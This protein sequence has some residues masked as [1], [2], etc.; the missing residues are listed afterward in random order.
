ML[1]GGPDSYLDIILA[2]GFDGVFL[3]V[4]DV[5]YSFESLSNGE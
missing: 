1:M 5:F 2:G 3:D 4:V